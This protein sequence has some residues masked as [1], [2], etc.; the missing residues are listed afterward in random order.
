MPV[1]YVYGTGQAVNASRRRR[2]AD[3]ARQKALR[4]FST[5]HVLHH[6]L[7]DSRSPDPHLQTKRKLAMTCYKPFVCNV[8][9]FGLWYR[10]LLSVRFKLRSDLAVPH[11]VISLVVHCPLVALRSELNFVFNSACHSLVARG[12]RKANLDSNFSNTDP[13][14]PLFYCTPPSASFLPPSRA[15]PIQSLLGSSPGTNAFLTSTS[16]GGS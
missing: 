10:L 3:P 7:L 8:M 4:A 15:H 14:A 11:G 13:R 5:L 16:Y 1:T 2:A 6:Q 9:V 12:T